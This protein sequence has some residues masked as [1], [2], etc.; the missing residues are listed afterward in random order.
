MTTDTT[1]IPARYLRS[2]TKDEINEMPLRRYEGEIKLVRTKA[3][4]DRALEEMA[5]ESLLGFDTETRPVFKKGKKPGPPS[6]LQLATAD[7]AYVFQINNL[8][9]DN[10]LSDILADKSIIKTGVA[11]RDD[12][13]GLLSLP[14]F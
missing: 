13:L 6:I 11:A 2:F 5:G 3:E 4:R 14:R 10:G 8:T 9:L 7:C 1:D 12:I